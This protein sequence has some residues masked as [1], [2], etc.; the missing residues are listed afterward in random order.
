MYLEADEEKQLRTK[1]L[2]SYTSYDSPFVNKIEELQ[3]KYPE[4]L[5]NIQ[6]ISNKARDLNEFSKKFFSKSSATTA[7]LTVDANAN[8]NIKTVSQYTA[9]HNKANQRLNGLY[10]LWKYIRKNELDSGVLSDEATNIANEAIEL[11]INGSLFVNDL[12]SVERPYCWAQS[13]QLLVTEGMKFLN[14]NVKIGPPS[15]TDSYIHLVIQAMA[16]ISN[17]IAGA[18]AYPDFFFYLDWYLRNEFGNDYM[19]EKDY[20]I[21]KNISFNANDII[22]VQNKNTQEIK[23]I[24]G[25]YFYNNQSE[26]LF[27]EIK[28]I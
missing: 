24:T 25:E 13:L 5:F 1:R 8:V 15:R 2:I 27:G 20:V 6:G 14:G 12:T 7:D 11:V 22:I 3:Q 17:Q 4:E 16:Y 28:N 10:L 19:N 23:E 21:S 9:E 26:Y 18:L